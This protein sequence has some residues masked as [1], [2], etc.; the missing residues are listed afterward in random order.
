MLEKIFWDYFKST[1][2]IGA[3]MASREFA[4][5]DLAEEEM[6]NIEDEQERLDG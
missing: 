5:D 1:G 2:D 6:M 3:Y 4:E